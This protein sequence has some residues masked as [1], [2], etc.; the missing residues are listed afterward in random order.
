MGLPGSGKSHVSQ[1][2]GKAA[3]QQGHRVLYREA[4]ILL[5]ELTDATIDGTR[6]D[7]IADLSAV[8]LLIIDDLCMRLLPA[9]AAEELLEVIMRR[10]EHASTILT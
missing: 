4:Y 3:I 7:V 5:E 9:T 6:K 2:L 10:Y 8:P 1:A